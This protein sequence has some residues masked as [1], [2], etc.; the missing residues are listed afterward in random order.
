M[1]DD[2][3]IQT[4]KLKKLESKRGNLNSS[5][6]NAYEKKIEKIIPAKKIDKHP[7]DERQNVT[8]Q[9]DEKQTKRQNDEQTQSS[10]SHRVF[11]DTN[12]YENW[13]PR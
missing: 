10:A 2:I 9:K 6:S 13:S 1:N 12:P 11:S 5:L 7:K 4:A 8:K 3:K